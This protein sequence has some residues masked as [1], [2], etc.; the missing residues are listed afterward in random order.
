MVG[1]V[2]IPSP[3]DMGSGVGREL[4]ARGFRVLTCLAG[5]SERS[6]R[7]AEG[8]GLELADS[9]DALVAS[10]DIVLSILPPAAAES[11]AAEAADALRRTGARPAFADCNAISPATARRVAARIT[12]ADPWTGLGAGGG[13]GTGARIGAGAGAGTGAVFI[14][15]GIIGAAPGKSGLPTRF[16]CSGPDTTALE[17]LDG[18]NLRVR[19]LGDEVGQ[20]SAMKMVYAAVTKGTF[21]LHAAAL[22]AARVHGLSGP[23]H[24]ELAESLPAEHAAMRRMTPR[25]P[26]DAARWVGEMHEI[27]ETLAAAGLPADFHRGAARVFE[28]LAR[29]PIAAE[30]RETVDP[31]RTLD[32]ALDVY[33]ETLASIRDA[34]GGRNGG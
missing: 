3:G 13:A 31:S 23:F 12:G 2:A 17:A 24:A 5:R 27:A 4:I 1:T 11:F 32:D 15:A 10:A 29:T 33:A 20:A 16:Y 8:A 30:T 18:P 7:L 26:L 25:L 21:T 34:V 22:L 28:L 19:R 9:L 6:H 14:D